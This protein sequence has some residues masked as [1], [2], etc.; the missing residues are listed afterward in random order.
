MQYKIPVQIENED[1]IM[2]GLSLRQIIVILVGGTIGYAVFNG[3]APNTGP[4]IAALPA[5]FI[6]VVFIVTAVFKNHEMTFVPFILSLIRY[7]V[8]YADRKWQKGDD[9][10]AAT[11]IGFVSQI[12]SKKEASVDFDSK[13]DKIKNIDDK[14]DKLK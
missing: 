10:F 2:F 4:E 13:I 6:V 14:L 12:S 3:L 9:S 11:D 8:N 1:P 5:I 7:K